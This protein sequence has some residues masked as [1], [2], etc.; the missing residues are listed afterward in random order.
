MGFVFSM[1]RS[2]PGQEAAL[3]ASLRSAARTIVENHAGSVVIC[4][5]DS[6]RELVWLGSEALGAEF[7]KDRLTESWLSFSLAF[8]DGWY[9]LPAPPYQ[10]WN[11]EARTGAESPLETLKRLL[12]LSGWRAGNDHV[13]GRSV[14][15]TTEDPRVYVGFVGL[16]ESWLR[17]CD[18]SQWMAAGRAHGLVWRPLFVVYRVAAQPGGAAR[19]SAGDRVPHIP[20]WRLP[21]AGTA[22]TL[23]VECGDR[24]AHARC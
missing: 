7:V 13:V 24:P 8:V 16:T 17:Q 23:P 4:Q 22:S 2:R 21:H 11:L 20:F 5:T 15:R 3:L 9:R 12:E 18:V 6:P 10:V 14:F 1:F 19:A